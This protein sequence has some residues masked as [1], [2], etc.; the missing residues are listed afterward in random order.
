MAWVRLD[1]AFLRN[2]KVVAAPPSAR[3]LYIAGLCWSAGALTDGRIPRT[4]LPQL[5]A[6]SGARRKD[7]ENLVEVGLWESTTDAYF[8]PDYL[9]YN[10]SSKQIHE[11]RARER[12]KK[13]RQRAVGASSV[14]NGAAGRFMSRH[15]SLGDNTGDSP[16][17]TAGESRR[18][19]PA[20]PSPSPC[21]ESSSTDT[22][23]GP[24]A[25]EEEI[26]TATWQRMATCHLRLELERNPGSIQHPDGWKRTDATRCRDLHEQRARAEIAAT[27]TIS[28]EQLA[29]NLDPAC[30]P[31]DGGHARALA[32][33]ADTE[34]RAEAERQRH[35]TDQAWQAEAERHLSDL[36]TARRLELER[37]AE[38]DT[39]PAPARIRKRAVHARLLQLTMAATTNGDA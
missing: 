27:P 19:S 15:L 30:G 34:A 39:A 16:G 20:T 11:E 37:Q 23:V 3:L 31:D 33:A 12:E 24:A 4:V 26:L 10:P 21:R 32:A 14:D 8:V 13:R 29:E 9:D 5:L 18:E 17:D 35:A 7:A 28:P 36:D 2:R 6:D 22:R 25:A 38:I 1:D